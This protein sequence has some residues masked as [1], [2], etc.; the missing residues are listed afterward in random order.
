MRFFFSFSLPDRAHFYSK[1]RKVDELSG[2]FTAGASTATNDPGFSYYAS[3]QTS[4][5][6]EPGLNAE[7]LSD[8]CGTS[9]EQPSP[10][11]RIVNL[12][13]NETLGRIRSVTPIKIYIG[14]NLYIEVK[15]FRK[16]LYVGFFK[17]EEGTVKNRFNFVLS[18]MEKVEEAF[19][20][21]K[22]HV[23]NSGQ[24]KHGRQQC[25]KEENS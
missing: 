24:L 5:A 6:R 17:E 4:E 14:N 9:D 13:P 7:F 8:P 3:G 11:I 21:I 2:E 10:T 23:K 22:H 20:V 25:V 19:Q 16:S 18:Q 1:K 12:A 15:E